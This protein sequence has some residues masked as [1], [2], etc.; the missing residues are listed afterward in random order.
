[1]GIYLPPLERR[2]YPINN[3]ISTIVSC[4]EGRIQADRPR[5][6]DP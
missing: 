3:A 2:M 4:T 6:S 1:M 5:D